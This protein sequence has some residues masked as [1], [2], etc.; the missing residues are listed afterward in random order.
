MPALTR[1]P[2]NV[3]FEFRE[4]SQHPGLRPGRHRRQSID[5]SVP[6]PVV[7]DLGH[8]AVPRVDGPTCD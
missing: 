3:S 2:E 6:P 8:A 5:L 4:H 1:S 7:R